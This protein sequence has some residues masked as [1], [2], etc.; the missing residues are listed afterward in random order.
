MRRS[1]LLLFAAGLLTG[2]AF[3]QTATKPSSYLP[4]IEPDFA[5]TMGKMKAA[6]A[7]VQ[8]RQADLLSQRYDLANRPAEGVTMSRGKAVQQ[9][10]RAKPAAGQ[11]WARPRKRSGAATISSSARHSAAPAIPRRITPTP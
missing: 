1:F 3:A 9:G 10:V 4:V 6:K 5:T 7:G 11:T 8:K 2:S